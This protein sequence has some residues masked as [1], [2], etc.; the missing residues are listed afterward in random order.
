MASARPMPVAEPV[1]RATRLFPLMRAPFRVSVDTPDHAQ[2]FQ[3]YNH[4]FAGQTTLL[5]IPLPKLIS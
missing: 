1:T 5:G 2:G 4:H 3:H